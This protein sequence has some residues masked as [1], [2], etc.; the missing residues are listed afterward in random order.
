MDAPD[1]H[2]R[3]LGDLRRAVLDGDG[4]TEPELR[5]AAATGGPLPEPLGSYVAK[6]RDA[7]YR[8]TDTDI[9]GLKAAGLGEEEIFEITVATALGAALHRMQAGL[10]ATAREGSS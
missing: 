7:S 2:A 5:V 8:V 10:R 4:M 3:R 1:R 9:A 6:V